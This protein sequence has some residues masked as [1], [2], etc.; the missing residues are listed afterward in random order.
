MTSALRLL[1]ATKAS[2]AGFTNLV[3]CC[4]TPATSLPLTERSRCS[5]RTLQH[6]S[7]GSLEVQSAD[8]E[9]LPDA[10]WLWAHI[11]LPA[12]M[13]LTQRSRCSLH[14]PSRESG[15][16]LPGPWLVPAQP[17]GSADWHV[18]STLPALQHRPAFAHA[19]RRLQAII[20]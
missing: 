9:G 8:T 11:L 16:V 17:H 18:D 6:V 14:S 3:Y 19:P 2:C 13:P 1:G 4:S 5:L 10:G 20:C 15:R 12:P 7:C